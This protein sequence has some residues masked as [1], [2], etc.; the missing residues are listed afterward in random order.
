MGLRFR[1]SFKIAPGVRINVGKKSAGLSIGGKG[2]RYSV[3]TSGRR[4]ASAGI[5][6]SGLYY[7]ST[8]S[9]GSRAKSSA[10]QQRQ[11][12]QRAER[13]R[14]KMEQLELAQ[15][16]VDMYEN[17]VELLKSIHKEADEPVDWAYL[18]KA[19]PPFQAGQAGPKE[20]EA[21]QALEAYQPTGLERIFKGRQLLKRQKLELA[22]TKGKEEDDSAYQNWAELTTLSNDVLAG[23]IDAY[24]RAIQE[25]DPLGDL[26]EFGSG[27]EFS[28]DDPSY[29]EVQFDVHSEEMVPLK[30]KKLTKTGKVSE[31]AL[32]KT[33]YYELQQDY[34]CSSVIRIAR[35]LF[36]LLPLEKVVIHAYDEMLY[37][38]IGHMKRECILS[39]IIDCETIE[40]LNLDLI[41]CSDA[42]VNFPHRMHFRKT[43]GF[44]PVTAL[45]IEAE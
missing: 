37:T 4:T 21:R 31:K 34:V 10:Y 39:V 28:T 13:E 23:D 6:G 11:A 16:E 33:R 14:E 41:D 38:E 18:A 15:L 1:K 26:T 5:P 30:E 17:Q 22:V 25:M 40:K 3:N 42:M 32:T 2:V 27:F 35:D 24:F 44:A 43:K 36:A 20:K 8:K 19:E 12:L 9:G 7:T 45:A 29:M